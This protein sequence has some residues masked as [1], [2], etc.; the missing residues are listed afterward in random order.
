MARFKSITPVEV[1]Y[2]NKNI[3]T[4][5]TAQKM[6]KELSDKGKIFEVIVILKP[7]KPL[8]DRTSYGSI[9]LLPIII[10]NLFERLLLQGVQSVIKEK[11]LIL[12]Y[13]FSFRNKH[14]KIGQVHSIKAVLH[15]ASNV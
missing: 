2:I 12:S 15:E 5:I 10:S 4:K 13:Q 11:H 9:S 7:S 1:N 3:S 8:E 6:L 14:S